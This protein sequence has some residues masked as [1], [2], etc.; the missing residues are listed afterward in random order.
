[1]MNVHEIAQ[2]AHEVNRAYCQSIGD[3]SQP[4]WADAP[5]WQKDSA[6]NGVHAHMA[7][8]LTPEQSHEKWMEE[9]VRDGWVYGPVKDPAKK[10]HPCMVPYGELPLEQRTKDFLFRGVV[11]AVREVYAEHVR[12]SFKP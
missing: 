3:D 2:V 6:V 10:E 4:S 8:T 5:Q 9:K 12:L 11:H 1:M 7:A